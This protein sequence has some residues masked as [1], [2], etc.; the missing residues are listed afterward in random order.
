MRILGIDPGTA[1]VG[2]AL[3]EVPERRGEP[4]ILRHG[5]IVTDKRLPTARR[6]EQIYTELRQLISQI[7]PDCICVEQ[8][9]FFSNAKTAMAVA[10]ARGVILLAAESAKKPI[11]SYTPAQV[12]L[13]VTE[14]GRAKKKEVQEKVAI[15][16]DLAERPKPDDI[17]D[18][19]AIV[20]THVSLS[21]DGKER[22]A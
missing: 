3:V 6:L 9:F 21:R 12:K 11:Y 17:A 10:E 13:A 2:Y 5:A 19:L 7:E 22:L 14:S 15:L 8:L 20:W 16:Y 1:I 18:A 4:E